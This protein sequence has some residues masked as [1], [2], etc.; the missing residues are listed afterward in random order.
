MTVTLTPVHFDKD[1]LMDFSS[2]KPGPYLNL[3]VADTGHGI[4]ETLIENIF[5]PF[6]TTKPLGEGTGLGLSV[7]HGI[8]KNHKGEIKVYSEPDR[9]TSIQVFLPVLRQEGCEAAQ[10]DRPVPGG[11]EHILLID[12]E[13]PLMEFGKLTLERLGYQV[14]EFCDSRRAYEAFK[15]DPEK[16][17]IVVTDKAMPEMTGLTLAKRIIDLNVETPVVM[18]TG[19]GDE[20]SKKE[21]EKIGIAA[22]LLKPVIKRE[23]AETIRRVLDQKKEKGV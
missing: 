23:L 16:F 4:P 15:T 3:Q 6:F 21:A 12:D 5:D 1:S 8:V 18:C 13:T 7:V 2:L 19:F 20:I 22:M 11:T 9:G 10:T 14:S 17:D